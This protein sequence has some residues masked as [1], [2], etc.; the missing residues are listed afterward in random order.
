LDGARLSGPE[1]P[2]QDDSQVH[3]VEVVLSAK[4]PGE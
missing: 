4:H 3:Q 2:L 1:I